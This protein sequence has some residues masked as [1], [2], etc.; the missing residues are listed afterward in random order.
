MYTNIS[1][2]QVINN[3]DIEDNSD[4]DDQDEILMKLMNDKNYEIEN[5]RDDIDKL[6]KQLEESETKIQN[7]TAQNMKFKIEI[8]KLKKNATTNDEMQNTI[9]ESMKGTIIHSPKKKIG[10]VRYCLH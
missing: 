3:S 4:D 2:V 8:E 7:L 6:K 9:D 1:H 5:L 10:L